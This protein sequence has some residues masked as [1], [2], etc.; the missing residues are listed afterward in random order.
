M[1]PRS[2]ISH[3]RQYFE[4][5]IQWQVEHELCQTCFSQ[6]QSSMLLLERTEKRSESIDMCSGLESVQV[7]EVVVG[8][9]F[10]C[11]R[12]KIYVLTLI[13]LAVVS[14]RVLRMCS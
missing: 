12:W 8:K 13:V 7:L 3:K 4:S 10:I 6:K 1:L 11:T 2:I 5:Y 9:P 14:H